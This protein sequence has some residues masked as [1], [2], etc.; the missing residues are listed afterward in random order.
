MDEVLEYH[1]F[2]KKITHRVKAEGCNVCKWLQSDFLQII[3]SVETKLS[4]NRENVM[5]SA[6]MKGNKNWGCSIPY[7]I[8]FNV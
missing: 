3:V 7:Q 6:N 8:Q 4:A 1:D 2:R 5:V